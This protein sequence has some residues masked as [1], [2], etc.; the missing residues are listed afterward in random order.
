MERKISKKRAALNIFLGAFCVLLAGLGIRIG[1]S[2]NRLNKYH[3][4]ISLGDKY[5]E[6]MDYENAVLAFRNAIE[7]SEKRPVGYLKLAVTYIQTEEY[8]KAY[9]ILELAEENADIGQKEEDLKELKKITET[10]EEEKKLKEEEIFQSYIQDV[11]VPEQGAANLGPITA[12]L[13]EAGIWYDEALPQG[14]LSSLIEDLDQDG[15]QEML[16]LTLQNDGQGE[17][18]QES[19]NKYSLWASVY[20]IEEGTVELKDKKPAR[21]YNE[22]E[23]IVREHAGF[24]RFSGQ[25]YSD[26]IEEPNVDFTGIQSDE[27]YYYVTMIP[28]EG[29]RLICFEKSKYIKVDTFRENFPRHN[30]WM[31]EYDGLQLQYRSSL[32]QTI[33]DN[34]NFSYYEYLFENGENTEQRLLYAQHGSEQGIFDNYADTVTAFMESMQL[35]AD[36]TDETASIIKDR[37]SYVKILDYTVRITDVETKEI[38]MNATDFT[39]LREHVK[40]PETLDI[41]IIKKRVAD[42]Y[43]NREDGDG[44]YVA[45]E[46]TE[47]GDTVTLIVRYQM[48]EDEAEEIIANG[49]FPSANRFVALVKV[50]KTTGEATDEWGNTWNILN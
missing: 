29:H 26:D 1:L 48:P 46:E 25:P 6:E 9:E 22:N 5:L 30:L 44:N 4:Q 24:N 12:I 21:G 17:W 3:Q 41:E 10:K 31:M 20:E 7:I 34:E 19:I 33:Y 49:G 28:T 8:G 27:V 35:S 2:V 18:Y 36:V 39:E 50:N 47:Q 45:G 40:I 13:P 37:D 15:V 32:T 23:T 14:I 42:Y 11:L 16:I 43:N 38:E